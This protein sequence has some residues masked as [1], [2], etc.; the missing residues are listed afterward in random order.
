[1]N[2]SYTTR[3]IQLL[4]TDKISDIISV[5][6]YNMKLS[7]SC[8]PRQYPHAYILLD[9]IRSFYARRRVPMSGFSE[10]TADEVG[11]L[12]R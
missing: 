5:P 12:K 9:R 7:T 10:G 8:H 2:I 6:K 1:M 4:D 11:A 3:H